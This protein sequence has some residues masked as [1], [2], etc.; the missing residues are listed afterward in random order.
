MGWPPGESICFR[1]CE[2]GE[3]RRAMAGEHSTL[4]AHQLVAVVVA[5]LQASLMS[6]WRLNQGSK[7]PPSNQEK[8]GT[9]DLD[10][11]PPQSCPADGE[12]FA[13]ELRPGLTHPHRLCHLRWARSP[14]CTSCW[15]D[16]CSFH[17]C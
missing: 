7:E 11:G 17:R 16:I 5:L 4:G 15:S 9:G 13:T 1:K 10:L 8:A 2:E 6:S 12:V 14:D 3:I